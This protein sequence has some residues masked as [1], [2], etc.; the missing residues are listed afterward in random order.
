[1]ISCLPDNLK[2]KYYFKCTFNFLLNASLKYLP[3]ITLLLFV[4]FFSNHA[5]SQLQL[6]G[7][8]INA[9]DGKPV[10]FASIGIS[11]KPFR[12]TDV[13]GN[14]SIPVPGYIS[15]DSLAISSVGFKTL[16]LPVSEAITL[17]EFRLNEQ[18]TNLQPLV[19]RSYLNEAA[20]GS[21]SEV[22]GYFRSWKTTGTGGEIG[23][24][25]YINH[26]E[27]KLERV[28]FKVNNQC[29]TC[30]VR[31]HIRE[32]IDDL[33]GD[34]IL[35]DSISTEIKRLSFDDRFSEFDLSN[36]NLVFKQRSILV[37][38][39]VLHCT[40]SGASDCSFCF[41]GTEEGKYMYKTRRQ[42]DWVESE[43]DFSIYM[44]LIYKY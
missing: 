33:P 12:Q 2:I 44:R 29:D 6:S 19:I 4:F 36:Y 27:Y 43:N 5:F 38:L 26:D 8:V 25:F 28:R 42:Y 23:K 30:Q 10:S 18:T 21:K 35:Y 24:V 1:M 3:V 15:N 13:N 20:S 11:G 40:H 39:E 22:T 31:L 32:I 9:R 37:S 14:F 17:T 41:I 16:K 7:K 34:E